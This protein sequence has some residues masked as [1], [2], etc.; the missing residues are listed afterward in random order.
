MLILS[1]A[2]CCS[3]FLLRFLLSAMVCAVSRDRAVVPLFKQKHLLPLLQSWQLTSYFINHFTTL[4]FRAAL[5]IKTI[6]CANFF[7]PLAMKLFLDTNRT[8]SNCQQVIQ[9][10]SEWLSSPQESRKHVCQSNAN[11]VQR[12]VCKLL[13]LVLW[14]P[15]NHIR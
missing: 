3:T 12:Q 13:F 10:G 2:L 11:N 4:N 15:I 14:Q 6:I 9:A 8:N 7:F 5:Y 1:G